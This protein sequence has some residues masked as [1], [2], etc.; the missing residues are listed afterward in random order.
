MQEILSTNIISFRSK[1]GIGNNKRK[2]NIPVMVARFAGKDEEAEAGVVRVRGR[3]RGR[4]DEEKRGRRWRRRCYLDSGGDRPDLAVV[5]GRWWSPE[6]GE[7]ERGEAAAV[8]NET[9]EEMRGMR[10]L[11]E[12]YGGCAVVF[13][14]NL[15][16]LH[17]CSWRRKG[18]EEAAT[19]VFQRW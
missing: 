4:R 15:V 8:R 6:N 10:T 17:R 7:G 2:K 16:V 13:V 9:G 12:S 3:M 11:A 19:V 14:E 5:R 1:L 18:E